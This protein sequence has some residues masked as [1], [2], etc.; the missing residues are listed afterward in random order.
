MRHHS[1]KLPMPLP[2]LNLRVPYYQKQ[3]RVLT[4]FYLPRLIQQPVNI[5]VGIGVHDG[6]CSAGCE[7][8]WVG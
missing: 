5:V 6:Y 4:I 2:L 1:Y 7:I 8:E 3:E